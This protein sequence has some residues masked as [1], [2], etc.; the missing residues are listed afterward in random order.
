MPI[1]KT[2]KR[3]PR[4]AW[5]IAG[6]VGLGAVAIRVWK[7][8]D[9]EPSDSTSVTSVGSPAATAAPSPVITPPVIIQGNDGSG[10]MESLAGMIGVFGGSF[11]NALS[12]IGGLAQ[13]D[14]SL[15]GE[16]VT[17][18][19]DIAKSV[20]AQGG[21]APQ[22]SI[23][24]PPVITISN[25]IVQAPTPRPQPTPTATC[26]AAFPRHNPANGAPGPRSCYK[27][28]KGVT[29]DKTYP[30]VHVYQDSHR[31]GVKNCN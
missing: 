7:G 19:A 13:G 14:Q 3:A 26:P 30:Y 1:A 10:A 20:I 23:Q 8:R 16:G 27:C 2:V 4:W 12:I 22:P 6:G 21:S 17:N 29:G 31:V 18:I 11:D 9:A 5:Y 24:V 28:Q 25:P 15:A